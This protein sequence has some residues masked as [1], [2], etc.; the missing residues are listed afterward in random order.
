MEEL[1]GNLSSLFGEKVG[2]FNKKG[3]CAPY[4]SRVK[5]SE[6]IFYKAGGQTYG[7]RNH[8]TKNAFWQSNFRAIVSTRLCRT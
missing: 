7:S 6:R 2:D 8:Y 4:K 3:T 1:I 5:D